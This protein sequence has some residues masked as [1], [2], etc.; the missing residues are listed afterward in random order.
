[1][2]TPTQTECELAVMAA[3]SMYAGM[4]NSMM[5]FTVNDEE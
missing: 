5:I 3:N 2:S 4:K 1:M